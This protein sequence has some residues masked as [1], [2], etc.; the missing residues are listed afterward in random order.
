MIGAGCG[1]SAHQVGSSAASTRARAVAPAAPGA[2]AS[3]VGVI[4]G[5]S[6]ALRRGDV[7]AAARYFALPSEFVNGPGDALSIHTEAEARAANASLPCGAVLVSA[8]RH[9]RF[10]N[11]I[12]RLTNRPGADGG[13]GSGAGELARTDFVIADGHIL[14]WIRAPEGGSGV[15]PLPAAPSTQGGGPVV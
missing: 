8:H 13:C 2:A 4:R 14:D 1:S 12:F 15:V 11:A 5:W 10:V 9:G 3:A 6:N 7:D